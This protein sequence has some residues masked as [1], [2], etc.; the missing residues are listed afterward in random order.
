MSQLGQSARELSTRRARRERVYDS[1]AWSALATAVGAGVIALAC[2]LLYAVNGSPTSSLRWPGT[3][4]LTV[5]GVAI[6]AST[7]CAA[8][9]AAYL[10]LRVLQRDAAVGDET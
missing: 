1:G 9:S 8:F 10:V 4:V 5:L 7:F 2:W 3:L 6:V